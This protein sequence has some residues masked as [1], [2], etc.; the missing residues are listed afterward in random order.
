M[1]TAVATKKRRELKDYEKKWTLW[2]RI[3]ESKA[4]YLFLMPYYI[5]FVMF[6]IVP[7][8]ISVYYSF[9]YYN[10]LEAPQFIGWT[11][12]LNLFLHDDVF[13]LAIQNTFIFAIITGPLGYL[14]AFVFAWFINELPPKVRAIMI[15]VFYAPTISGQVYMVWSI[16]FSGDS[17]GWIN[18]VLMN[19]GIINKAVQWTTDTKTMMFVCIV[20][21]LWSSLGAGFLSHVA[22]LQGID[23]ELYEAGYVDG[24]SNRWQE[25]WYI[26]LPSM[27]PQLLFA[28]VMSITSTFGAADI[29]TAMCGFPSTDYAVHTIVNHLQDYGDVR[30]EMGYASAIAVLLFGACLGLNRLIQ[31]LLQKVGT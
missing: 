27:K 16:M 31:N 13:I 30:F 15:L 14:A 11:N 12:F 24:I 29:M 17:Y 8:I 18:G 28:A 22:G 21:A 6:T 3:K 25:L 5:L 23:K 7:V 20:V 4:S 19:W 26:T 2:G 9:T 1:S 10:I